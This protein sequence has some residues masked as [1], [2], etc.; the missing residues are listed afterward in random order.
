MLTMTFT[1]FISRSKADM[2][3]GK[4][5]KKGSGVF[6]NWPSSGET[7]NIYDTAGYPSVHCPV[8]PFQIL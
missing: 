8:F 7:D 4:S 3:A 2:C 1:K 6:N 5:K